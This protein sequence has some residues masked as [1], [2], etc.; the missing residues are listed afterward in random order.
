MLDRPPIERLAASMR[1]ID[2]GRLRLHLLVT[3]DDNVPVD[4]DMDMSSGLM[5][6]ATES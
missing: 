3:V 4:A 5:P 1:I 6:T 2:P